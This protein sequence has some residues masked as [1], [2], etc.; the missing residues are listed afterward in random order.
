MTV[1]SNVPELLTATLE[2]LGVKTAK[3]NAN[4]ES[5]DS[6]CHLAVGADV[7][8]NLTV[9]NNLAESAKAGGFILLEEGLGIADAAIK[10]T[11]LD[12][13]A[14]QQSQIRTYLL[15]RKVSMEECFYNNNS[16]KSRMLHI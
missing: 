4:T 5:L 12:L 9:L 14:K 1:A 3:K 13:V 8:S 11:G 2:P 15:F 16:Y 7:L 6:N 10:K